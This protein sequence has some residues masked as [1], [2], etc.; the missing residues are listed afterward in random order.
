M[1]KCVQDSWS[2]YCYLTKSYCK[3]YKIAPKDLYVK[4][5]YCIGNPSV[6]IYYNWWFM[7]KVD[8]QLRLGDMLI[9]EN[10]GKIFIMEDVFG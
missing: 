1:R 7:E 5:D 9:Q 6:E 10:I 2:Q 8:Y 4:K 3:S